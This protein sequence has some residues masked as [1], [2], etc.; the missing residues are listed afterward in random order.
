MLTQK[1]TTLMVGLGLTASSI[2]VKA[3]MTPSIRREGNRVWIENVVCPR[4]DQGADCTYAGALCSILLYMG[5]NVAYDDLMGWSGQAFRVQIM[6]PDWC[7]SA[8]CAGPG[9]DTAAKADEALDRELISYAGGDDDPAKVER[10]RAA[11]VE[12][13]DQ[14]RPVLYVFE[15]CGVI[16]GYEDNGK[17]FLYQTYFDMKDQ[18]GVLEKWSWASA[19][20]I[21]Q[22]KRDPMSRREKLV[23][24]LKIAQE[25]ANTPS[26]GNYASGFKAYE[27]WIAQL[28]DDARF[29]NENDVDGKK[30][31]KSMQANAYCYRCLID[32]RAAAARYLRNNA[33]DVSPDAAGH[34]LKA[35]YLYDGIALRLCRHRSEAPSLCEKKPEQWTH[36]L[37]SSQ[38]ALLSEALA[39]DRAAVA[40]LGAALELVS[41]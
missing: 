4:W 40:E 21:G 5:D 34:L 30:L 29:K 39:A 12:S 33:R 11:M 32:A 10:R 20:I 15:E 24:S 26:Y 23:R 7:P 8:A 37:R 28:Q 25:I 2:A 38:A 22:P 9:F 41:K 31:A 19:T 27:L 3:G 13:I 6:Q 14:G 16:V 17:R 1:M 18:P 35:A 36:E